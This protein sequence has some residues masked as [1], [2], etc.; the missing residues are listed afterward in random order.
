M[1]ASSSAKLPMEGFDY[2]VVGGG[3]AGLVIATRLSENIETRVLVLEAGE[4]QLENPIINM[5]AMWPTIL[6]SEVDWSFLTTPQEHLKGRILRHPQGKALGG[7]SALNAEIFVAPAKVDIDAWEKLGNPGWNWATLSPYYR[8]FHTVNLP[9]GSNCQHLGI[10]GSDENIKGIEGPIQVSFPIGSEDP[11]SKAWIETFKGINN[12]IKVDPFSGEAY[13]G[14]SNPSSIDPV[15]KTRSYAASAYYAPVYTRPNLTVLTGA[16]VNRVLLENKTGKGVV[17]SGV[18][19]LLNGEPQEA[20]ANKEVIIAA[21]AFQSPKIL[22]LSGIGNPKLL[23]SLDIP[24]IVDNPNVGENLQDHPIIG[25]SFEVIDGTPT[26]DSLLRQEPEVS[27]YVMEQYMKDRTGPLSYGSVTSHSLMPIT[28]T[29]TSQNSMRELSQLFEDYALEHGT[30]SAFDFVKSV[31]LSPKQVSSCILM[32]AAQINAHDDKGEVGGKNY[33]QMPGPGDFIT[34]ASLLSHPLS[35]GSVHI[36]SSDVNVPPSID[37]KYLSHPLD[38]EVLSRHLLSIEALATKQPLAQYLK[39]HGRRNHETARFNNDLDL[40]KDYARRTAISNNHPSCS[41]PMLPREK[42]GVVDERL[43][44]YG[45]ENLRIVD[46]SIMPLIPLALFTET[47]SDI[48][49]GSIEQK[50]QGAWNL[51]NALARRSEVLDFFLMASSISGS[52]GVAT[53]SNYCATNCFLDAFARYRHSMGL[54]GTSL[55]LGMI[56][57]VGY[58]HEHPEIEALLLRKGVHPLNEDELAAQKQL[59]DFGMDSMLAAEFRGVMFRVFRVDVPFTTLLNRRTSV[60]SLTELV[61]NRLLKART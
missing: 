11:L 35:R 60:R 4:N 22:E 6:G 19:F 38:I 61:A 21:G 41:C 45:T 56:S 8:K 18:S 47:T 23:K 52:I 5:P 57:E 53:E 3:T 55:G 36:T 9:S 30:N 51:H 15:T 12:A 39:P 26:A 14:Y 48:W 32:F 49:Q 10:D 27:R 50:V 28:N 40:A 2:I 20:K 37:P 33:L 7:S 43:R 17:A 25:V 31:T 58:L 44:V 59:V 29:L 34:L 42:G 16:T 1:D 24:V 54:P 46:S 13:G